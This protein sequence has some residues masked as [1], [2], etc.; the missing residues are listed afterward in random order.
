MPKTLLVLEVTEE[1]G[2]CSCTAGVMHIH[3]VP[4]AVLRQN[5]IQE[6][7][8]DPE[9]VRRIA[10]ESLDARLEELRDAGVVVRRG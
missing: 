10:N 6:S 3:V 4:E 1:D 9:D 8:Y 7:M 5:I 2:V